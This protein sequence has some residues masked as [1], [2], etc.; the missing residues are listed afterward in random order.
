MNKILVQIVDDSATVRSVLTQ[1]I[2]NDPSLEVCG[3][4]ANPVFAQRHMEKQWPDVIILDLEMPEMDGLTF[5][6]KI[7]STHPTPVII[8][9][10]YAEKG[11]RKAM[12]AIQSGAVDII[13]KPKLGIKDYLNEN[14]TLLIESIKAAACAK[15]S[16]IRLA[17]LDKITVTEKFDADVIISPDQNKARIPKTDRLIA[18]GSSTGGTTAIEYLLSQVPLGSPGIVIVQHMP[19]K[20]TKAFSERLNSVVDIDVKEAENGDTLRPGLAVVAPGG[21]HLLIKRR[22]NQY[23][24]ELKEGPLV[25]RHRP[26]VDVLFRSV[27]MAAGKNSVGVIL[28]GMGDDGAAGMK[29]MFDSGA[30][31]IA[32]DED[33]CVVFG[34]PKM[35]IDHGGVKSVL[36]LEKISKAMLD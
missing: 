23:L 34:M 33:T 27:S 3:S 28:T 18:I 9:S 17:Q 29:E 19:E 2:Q 14:S 12:D 31:T 35:A 20:F 1:L 10:A 36:A 8:C 11:A 21:K 26:S 6:K 32:Q 25:R 24:V 15:I 22:G 30:N 13:T 5:L 4:A 7:M 16:K